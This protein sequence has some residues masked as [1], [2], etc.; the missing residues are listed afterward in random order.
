MAVIYQE[1]IQKLVQTGTVSKLDPEEITADGESWFIPHHIVSHN[2]NSP[3]FICSHQH[4]GL[5]LKDFLL[6]EPRLDGVQLEFH[7][8]AIAISGDIKGVSPSS[9]PTR[10]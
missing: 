1:E 3:A 7:E 4:Q 8:H 6:P 9:P 10:R 5:N 2:K